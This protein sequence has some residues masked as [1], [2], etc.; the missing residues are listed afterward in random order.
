VGRDGL[1]DALLEELRIRNLEDLRR[2]VRTGEGLF[3]S[4]GLLLPFDPLGDVRVKFCNGSKGGGPR[5]GF[6]G[7]VGNEGVPDARLFDNLRVLL[8]T[9][10]DGGLRDG[11]LLD[12]VCVV[13][14][15]VGKHITEGL[16]D[17]TE[18][19]R[20]FVVLGDS[21]LNSL[22]DD[23]SRFS[24]RLFE[25]VNGVFPDSV[26]DSDSEL[27]GLFDR[28]REGHFGDAEREGVRCEEGLRDDVCERFLEELGDFDLLR[29]RVRCEVPC[30]LFDGFNDTLRD[31]HG[32]ELL[33]G[34]RDFDGLGDKHCG[35]VCIGLVEMLLDDVREEPIFEL[36]LEFNLDRLRERRVFI[37]SDLSSKTLFILI[38]LFQKNLG[39]TGIN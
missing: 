22:R 21:L 31:E 9:A 16:R 38:C 20:D 7:N 33:E 35:D 24:D 36:R 4:R 6:L 11:G 30:R 26:F 5:D 13:L 23:L 17:F 1:R 18:G 10:V 37:C 39:K 29:D 14:C 32:E 34:L 2:T 28:L 3:T 8:R 12:N 27:G 15:D 19:L 25:M